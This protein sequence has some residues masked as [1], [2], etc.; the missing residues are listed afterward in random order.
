MDKQD[1]KL[2]TLDVLKTGNY[3]MGLSQ[4]EVSKF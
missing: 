2:K 3:I 4:L 1:H